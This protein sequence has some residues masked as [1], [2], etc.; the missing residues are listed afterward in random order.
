MPV[1]YKALHKKREDINDEIDVK[2]FAMP[3]QKGEE[4]KAGG[5]GRFP[6][7][8]L[9]FGAP[10]YLHYKVIHS[11]EESINKKERNNDFQ[12]AEYEI[13]NASPYSQAEEWQI[14]IYIPVI[15]KMFN[16]TSWSLSL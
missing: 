14:R 16:K 5:D 15:D 4:F 1:Q 9:Q 7:L 11:A 2:L 6:T 13:I 8:C 3:S 10:T 12:M